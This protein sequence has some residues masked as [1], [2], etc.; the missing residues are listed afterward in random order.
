MSLIGLSYIFSRSV[1]KCMAH[2]VS[3]YDGFLLYK[4]AIRKNMSPHVMLAD[5]P[6]E[7]NYI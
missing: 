6:D 3:S 5:I 7:V 4:N 2:V 1:G